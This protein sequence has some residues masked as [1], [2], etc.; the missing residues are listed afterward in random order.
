MVDLDGNAYNRVPRSFSEFHQKK[1]D[2]MI[3]NQLD[4]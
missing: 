2:E 1:E 3:D 4:I